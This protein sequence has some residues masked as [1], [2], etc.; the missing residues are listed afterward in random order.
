MATP[1]DPALER[2]KVRLAL[3]LFRKKAGYNQPSVAEAL[4]WSP[5]KV[6]RIEGGSVGVSV[7]DLR[8]LLDLY[9][10]TD[11]E[12]RHEL[13]ES[14]RGSRRP[15]WWSPYRDVVDPQFA[16]YLGFESTAD[17]LFAYHPTLI[18]G[19]LQT[20]DYTRALLESRNSPERLDAIVGLRGERQERLLRGDEKP[21]LNFLVDEASLRRW[22]GGPAVM[23][24]QLRYLKAV[25]EYPH[26][27][28]G[29]VPFTIGVH[30]VLRSGSIALTFTD[31]DDVLFAETAGG[32]LTTRNDQS[33][34]DDY[35][36]DFQ[37]S[38][39]GALFGHLMTAFIDEIIA[40][41]PNGLAETSA[42]LPDSP[43]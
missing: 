25:A 13:E 38:R 28:L 9:N 16:I 36:T 2:R 12:T 40:Q 43:S 20:E 3:R 7:T 5:S 14:T 21:E 11:A 42:G 34:V 10:V 31:D 15:P 6:I 37:N 39:T 41:Y 8:A 24:A 30:P 29:V 17:A 33:V 1:K 4:S 32:A 23:R 27:T 35:L 19:L 26:V 22:V 18:P